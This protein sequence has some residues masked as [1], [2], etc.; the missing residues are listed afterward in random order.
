M[1]R[2][3]TNE[4]EV[5]DTILGAAQ[6]LFAE[7]GYSGTTVRGIASRAGVTGAMIHYYFGNKEKLYRGI[8]QAAA[9]KVRGAIE[10]AAK[11]GRDTGEQLAR[12]IDAYTQFVV[13]N[14]DLVRMMNREML[15]GGKRLNIS[16]ERY[17][18]LGNYK[19]LRNIIATGRRRG[20]LRNIDV[21]L[22]PVS[23]I[24]MI[25]LFQIGQPLI[26]AALGERYDRRFAARLAEHTTSLF[27]SGAAGGHPRG[28][29]ARRPPH[30]GQ[31]P[32]RGRKRVRQ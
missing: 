31:P 4:N 1:R 6:S 26:S 18:L 11:E 7:R 20:E 28:K 3:N 13:G 29:P 15:A 16:G 21:D 24:G 19:L 32:V 2:A 23:L 30:R 25:Q 10:Q 12:F 5:R 14:P 27:L 17:G 8:L 22:A 9:L